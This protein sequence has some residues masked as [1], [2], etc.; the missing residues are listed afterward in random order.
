MSTSYE[1]L[2]VIAHIYAVPGDRQA[3]T[4]LL[5]RLCELGRSVSATY[6]AADV[7]DNTVL[8]SAN[9]GF[10]DEHLLQYQNY[11]AARDIR[12]QY[13]PAMK[14]GK[15]YRELEAVPDKE[16]Y[17]ENEFIQ[18][19]DRE[20]GFYYA[21]G[22][23]VS[24]HGLWMDVLALNRKRNDGPF[25]DTDKQAIQDC[26]P[27]LSRAMELHRTFVRLEERFGAVLSVLDKLLV[28]LIVLDQFGRVVVANETARR[29]CD[30]SGA[31]TLTPDG[32]IRARLDSTDRSLRARISAAAQTSRADGTDQ[33]ATLVAVR[34][35]GGLPLLLEVMPLRDDGLPDSD[36]VVGVGVFVIDP[37]RSGVLDTGV[38][39]T[40]F[41]LTTAENDVAR[42]IVNGQRVEQVAESRGTSP[43]T[44]RKQIKTVLKKTGSANQADLVRRTAKASPPIAKSTEDE[45]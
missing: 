34:S 12:N 18:W 11:Y 31:I 14:P 4:D 10:S 1:L 21:L 44:V 27:H 45:S 5:P 42:A 13:L 32:R 43:E 35:D 17:D 8:V 37:E 33:G 29:A 40:L 38:L 30:E 20:L 6:Y 9:Y 36:N 16:A 22:A 26:L 19:A 7:D 24:A 23:K 3:W 15:V 41:G 25:P 39:A 28:G 2:D